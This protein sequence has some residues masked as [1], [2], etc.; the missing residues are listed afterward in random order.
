MAVS[1]WPSLATVNDMSGQP[2]APTTQDTLD[3]AAALIRRVAGWHIA[4]QITETVTLDHDGASVLVLPSLHVVE[5][6]S[7]K[8]ASTGV[9][10]TGWSWSSKGLLS[11]R[12]PCGFRSVEVTFTHGFESCPL[13][14]FPSVATAGEAVV[15]QQQSGPFQVS[16][17]AEEFA[18]SADAVLSSYMLRARP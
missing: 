2:G 8:N 4:P 3:R 5:V 6:A 17:A 9:E 13:D 1:D 16:Y 15:R 18:T 7:V 11:G 12:F 14:L 10:L